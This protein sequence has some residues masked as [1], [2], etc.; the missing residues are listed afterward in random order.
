MAISFEI[1]PGVSWT[2]PSQNFTQKSELKNGNSIDL[3]KP[4]YIMSN[5]SHQKSL[6][7]GAAAGIIFDAKTLLRKNFKQSMLKIITKI[8]HYQDKW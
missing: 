6:N 5:R 7:P 1:A 4:S 3:G 8:R 2:K